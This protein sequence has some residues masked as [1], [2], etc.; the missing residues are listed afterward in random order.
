M[1]VELTWSTFPDE[2]DLARIEIHRNPTA[3]SPSGDTLLTSVSPEKTSYIDTTVTKTSHYS[4][5]AINGSGTVLGL[6][7]FKVKIQPCDVQPIYPFIS[8]SW[9]SLDP[10]EELTGIEIHRSDTPF[11]NP[12]SSTLLVQLPGTDTSFEDITSYGD[13]YYAVIAIDKDGVKK[14]MDVFR[15][16]KPQCVE[17]NANIF[18]TDA[19]VQNYI[20]NADTSTL[21]TLSQVF[22]TWPRVTNRTFFSNPDNIPSGDSSNAWYF[23]ESLDSFVYPDNNPLT[24]LIVSPDKVGNLNITGTLSSNDGD[25]DGIGIVVA[26]DDVNGNFRFVTLWVEPGRNNGY[27]VSLR[28]GD[29]TN[30]GTGH[31]NGM[32]DIISGNYFLPSGSD[33]SGKEVN[34]QI[35][36]IDDFITARVSEFNNFAVDA[37]SEVTCDLTQLPRDGNTLASTARYGFAVN[38]Q[39][40]TFYQ[41]VSF[42]NE[43][44]QNN[45]FAYSAQGD[46]KYQYQ[47]TGW[48]LVGSAYPDFVGIDVI[49]NIDTGESFFIDGDSITKI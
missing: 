33:W 31:F 41:N 32:G 20:N 8:W 14:D 42:T 36:K 13:L 25:N 43:T 4:I 26:A 11:E 44:E 6:S 16:E 46:K 1:A 24:N 38:S 5:V 37:S 18:E 48:V 23:D 39:S 2:G 45:S 21:L 30:G 15:V 49:N 7:S 12:D 28:Y 17:V 19:Q 29:E 10:D 3:F 40:Q 34:F 22:D 9:A 35:T 47:S 27:D